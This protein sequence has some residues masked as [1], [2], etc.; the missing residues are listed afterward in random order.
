MFKEWIR[1]LKEDANMKA[2][3]QEYTAMIGVARWMFETIGKA[4]LD[5]LDPLR[6]QQELLAKDQKLNRA[7]RDIRKRIIE[8][9]AFNPG[10]DLGTCLVLFSGAKDAERLGDY[11]KNLQEV[12]I[13]LKGKP[14]PDRFLHRVRAVYAAIVA[15]FE[16]V[17]K[18]FA[19]G[20]AARAQAVMDQMK[21]VKKECNDIVG[22]I[23]DG[24]DDQDAKGAVA[25]SLTVRYFKRIAAHISN[26]ASGVINP[27]HK[28]DYYKPEED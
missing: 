12:A 24:P 11:C 5:D 27:V 13:F 16:E 28:I 17:A 14:Y 7:E 3:L 10:E 18:A 26:I 20:D 19:D 2:M 21:H 8:H 25:T 9:L 22:E 4:L 23:M 6:Y 1:A 15:Q